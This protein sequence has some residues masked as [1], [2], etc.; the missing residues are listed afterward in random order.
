MKIKQLL[1]MMF[2]GTLFLMNKGTAQNYQTAVGLRFGG[3]TN[4]ITIK[5]FINKKSALEGIVS[6]GHENFIVTG[7]Y[8]VHTGVDHSSLLNLYYGIGGHVG[9]F[10]NGSNYYYNNGH[11]YNEST[12]AGIDAILGLAGYRPDCCSRAPGRTLE[13]LLPPGGV[14]SWCDS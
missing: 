14:T 4:G 2:F 8:E 5:H 12:V 9:F 3:L 10:R 11:L 7:L 1:L 13:T 6:L